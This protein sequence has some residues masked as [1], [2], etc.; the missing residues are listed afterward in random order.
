MVFRLRVLKRLFWV[1]KYLANF[2]YVPSLRNQ[3]Y[4]ALNHCVSCPY[5]LRIDWQRICVKTL[6]KVTLSCLCRF[7]A[8]NPFNNVL[9]F[10]PLSLRLKLLSLMLKN[11]CKLD[12]LWVPWYV[13]VK[14][15]LNE[16]FIIARELINKRLNFGFLEGII[17]NK[18][19]FSLYFKPIFTVLQVNNFLNLFVFNGFWWKSR[20]KKRSLKI[21]NWY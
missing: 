19:I 3:I 11:V 1:K 10:Y 8:L 12:N 21:F 7:L 13:L 17:W 15:I 16:V 20:S 14:P 5:S 9:S 18:F 6:P 4:P 2:M